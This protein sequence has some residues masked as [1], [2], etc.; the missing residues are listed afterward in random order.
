MITTVRQCLHFIDGPGRRRLTVLGALVLLS[1]VLEP[2]GI[3][4]LYP[5]IGMIA[6]PAIIDRNRI[7]HRLY[8][9]VGA[10]TP[11]DFLQW[12]G[13]AIL[14]L[15]LL[16]SAAAFA[17]TRVRSR[18][19][20]RRQ[21]EL[22]TRLIAAYVRA[23]WL[24][25]L[26][27]NSA[28]LISHVQT[29]PDVAIGITLNAI[30]ELVSESVMLV[31]LVTLLAAVAPLVMGVLASAAVVLV[32]GLFRLSSRRVAALGRDYGVLQAKE[33]RAVQQAMGSAKEIRLLG[34]EGFFIDVFSRAAHARSRN[35]AAQEEMRWLPRQV[36]ELILAGGM[37]VAA[38][39]LLSQR[40]PA[41][42]VVS[43]LGIFA[44]ASFRMMP[45]F[46]RILAAI[47]SIQY[48]GAMVGALYQ[49]DRA[50][51]E[52]E[53]IAGGNHGT[54]ALPLTT[55]LTIENVSFDYPG[56]A[57]RVLDGV[58]AT[59]LRG[60][61]VGLVGASGAG[62]S[63]LADI[64]LGLLVPTGG[65]VKVDGVEIASRLRSWQDRIGY[66]PQSIYLTD[67]TL[68][69]NVALGVA[70]DGI[71]ATRLAAALETAQLS[72]LVESLPQGWDTP[73]GEL[74]QR[75]SGGQRQ[76]IG[77]A[78]ALYHDPDLIVM[79]EATSALDGETEKEISRAIDALRGHK[80]MLLI[81]H[82][83]STVRHCDA[84]LFMVD[85]RLADA[86]AFDE[87]VARN[88][89]FRRLVELADVR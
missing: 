66:V 72:A 12:V 59:I 33:M 5:F 30:L 62:K 65:R 56:G 54:L 53:P 44:A 75:L 67:D 9:M 45:S 7:L 82:R 58:S 13:A 63:T 31:T 8:D 23:P 17:V 38:M 77:I 89:D 16:K 88:A 80:T 51:A 20:Y 22:A 37:V 86:G 70:D 60:Q 52:P 6:E 69:R 41:G 42:T 55:A 19:T 1:S 76:R 11:L 25:R 10:A 27:R 3:G 29:Y 85:G 14:G 15:I 2:V 36:L 74:G 34:R 78:R 50:L 71:D 81:A 47:N 73:V 26:E 32:G 39:L 46:S 87:L 4:A 35:Q 21:A 24:W 28:D 64:I 18:L 49:E 84:I 57:R 40:Q 61:S 48:G 68:R 79:D 43:T 83:L